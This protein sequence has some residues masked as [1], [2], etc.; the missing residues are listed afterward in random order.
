MYIASK[1]SLVCIS[2][3]Y[4][5]QRRYNDDLDNVEDDALSGRL[6]TLTTSADIFDMKFAID[7]DHR[8]TFAEL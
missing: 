6:I 4:K 1:K 7:S 5:W 2:R 3:I 8:R